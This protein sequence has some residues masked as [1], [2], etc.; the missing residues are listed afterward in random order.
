MP[1]LGF[2]LSSCLLEASYQP[3]GSADRH[4]SVTKKRGKFTNVTHHH[5]LESGANMKIILIITY[6]QGEKASR[7]E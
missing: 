7:R 1:L 5:T 4:P 2:F 6:T 3:V